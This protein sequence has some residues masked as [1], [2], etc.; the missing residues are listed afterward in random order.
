[1]LGRQDR[2]RLRFERRQ[3]LEIV[4]DRLQRPVRGVP[5]DR[6]HP[7]FELA[8]EQADAHVER[9]LRS[10]C[11]SG[12]M[13]RQPDTWNPPIIT[14]TPA[15]R[16]GR[17]MSSARGNWFDCTPADAE[18]PNPPWRGT[19]E[20][21]LDLDPAVDLVDHRDVDRR[22]GSEHRPPRA[23]PRQAVEHGQRVRRNDG[24]RPRLNWRLRGG[25]LA[26]ADELEVVA[27]ARVRSTGH[28]HPFPR[29]QRDGGV[30]P[31][32]S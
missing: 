10:A 4:V 26:T 25:W 19:S 31:S 17:A 27:A 29:L 2:G 11:S 22:V 23:I 15:A 9:H 30:L 28:P 24:A 1:M 21:L 3:I 7:P 18:Q 5:Q 16:N 6:V 14:G 8:G 12:S 13:A 20:Q 32:G